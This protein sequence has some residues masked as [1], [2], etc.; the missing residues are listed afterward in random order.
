MTILQIQVDKQKS[1]EVADFEKNWRA[2]SGADFILNAPKELGITKVGFYKIFKCPPGVNSFD[3]F[4]RAEITGI[5]DD[6]N[7]PAEEF[8]KKLR[9]FKCPDCVTDTDSALY[10]TDPE[11]TIYPEAGKRDLPAGHSWV[12]E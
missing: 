4:L 6:N 9:E 8:L 5:K 1:S 11:Y 3:Y 7:A 2:Q 12:L 10:K